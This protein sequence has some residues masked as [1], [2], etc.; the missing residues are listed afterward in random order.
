MTRGKRG[1]M[2]PESARPGKK[3]GGRAASVAEGVRQELS[4]MLTDGAIKDPR[5][6]NVLLTITDVEMTP[7]LKLARVYFSVFPSDDDALKAV[8][9]G[10]RSANGEMKRGISARLGL[11][12]T[13]DLE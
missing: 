9:K 1:S 12:F 13:P 10:L 4:S 3:A 6:S 8:A 7:D 5:L 11:R 2:L